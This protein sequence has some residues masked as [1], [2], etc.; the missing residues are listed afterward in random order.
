[1]RE[2]TVQKD[3]EKTLIQAREAIASQCDLMKRKEKVLPL[4]SADRR[5]SK[6]AQSLCPS[7]DLFGLLWL[8]DLYDGLS[9]RGQLR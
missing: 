9:C 8:S 7:K 3:Y 5:L 4:T 1:M 2:E 6:W